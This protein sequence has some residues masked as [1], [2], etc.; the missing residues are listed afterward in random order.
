L[1]INKSFSRKALFYGFIKNQHST[2]NVSAIDSY[3]I[4]GGY[5][6]G[7]IAGESVSSS[8]IRNNAAINKA[9]NGL[10]DV[11][12]IVGYISS[13]T[14]DNNFALDTITTNRDGSFSNT[15]YSTYHG[16]SKTNSELKSQS[17]YESGLGW[18]FG[19]NDANPWRIDPT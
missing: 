2:G 11:N 1:K 12:R 14:L 15:G 5:Y 10:Y 19:N 3:Y 16:T 8:T 13:S 18:R 17:T 6:V 4:A 9:D 7:G